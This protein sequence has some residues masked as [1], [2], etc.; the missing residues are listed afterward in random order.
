MPVKICAFFTGLV[1][2]FFGISGLFPSLVFLPPPR[3]RYYDM[4]MVGHWGFLFTWLPVNPVHNIVY[5]IIGVAGVFAAAFEMTATAY[6]RGMFFLM[7]LFT[8]V[9]FLP[10]DIDHV[11]GL[12]PLFA[13][14]VMLHSVTAMLMYYYGFIY[15]LDRGGS[16]PPS[17][18]QTLRV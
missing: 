1:Y 12:M 5:I 15:P 8:V 16:E 14:N 10:F 11:W 13:W 7:F 2:L 17:Q 3:T 6:A 9:G 18:M 4:N